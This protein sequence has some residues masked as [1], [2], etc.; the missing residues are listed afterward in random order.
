[1]AAPD[2]AEPTFYRRLLAR[3]YAFAVLGARPWKALDPGGRV[4]CLNCGESVEHSAAVLVPTGPG[5]RA[6]LSGC[7]CSHECAARGELDRGNGAARVEALARKAGA[8]P[9][10]T[11]FTPAPPRALLRRYGG[12]LSIDEYRAA[13]AASVAVE[14]FPA[15][16]V[17]AIFIITARREGDEAHPDPAIEC[18]LRMHRTERRAGN[19]A[20]E[21]PPPPVAGV[22][23]R[24]AAEAGGGSSGRTRIRVFP[25]PRAPAPA[26]APAPSAAPPP[27]S[28]C[29]GAGGRRLIQLNLA[30]VPTRGTLRF[31]S[32]A[33]A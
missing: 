8:L 2:P 19:V 13:S 3:R 20:P 14:A 4:D 24:R 32:S 31:N 22:K 26:P 17:P 23:R 11:P 18:A 16:G 25:P 9:A 30:A 28:A 10:R 7:Y 33:R 29:E 15:R 5:A 27:V 6:P 21:P 1:M 12:P